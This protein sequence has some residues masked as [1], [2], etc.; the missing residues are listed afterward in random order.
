MYSRKSVRWLYLY[1]SGEKLEY[2]AALLGISAKAVGS[3]LKYM[4]L[5]CRP[6]GA[7]GPTVKINWLKEPHIIALRRLFKGMK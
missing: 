7:F 6:M 3:R 5:P 4:K 1:Y 2:I